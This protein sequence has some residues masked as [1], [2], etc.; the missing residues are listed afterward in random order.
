MARYPIPS[1]AICRNKSIFLAVP[2]LSTVLCYGNIMTV[3]ADGI[4]SET[5]RVK[6]ENSAKGLWFSLLHD[7][8]LENLVGAAFAEMKAGF[9]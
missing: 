6:A 8:C 5:G 4:A 1:P 7:K 2:F 9:I 3:Y